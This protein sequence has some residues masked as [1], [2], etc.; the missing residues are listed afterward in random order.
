M[1]QLVTM[2]CT[3]PLC[4][5]PFWQDARGRDFD[6]RIDNLTQFLCFLSTFNIC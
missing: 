3:L 6:Q 1:A 5:G 2:P 4:T